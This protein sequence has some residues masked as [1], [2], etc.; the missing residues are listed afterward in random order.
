DRHGRILAC[1][2]AD[3]PGSW[4]MPQGGIDKGE[5]PRI[6]ALRE[7]REEIG[8]CAGR[9][10]GEL[11]RTIRYE[12]PREVWRKGYRGQEQRYFLFRL[13]PWAKI[14]VG[15]AHRLDPKI[16]KEFRRVEFINPE[17]FMKRVQG[18]KVDA[19]REALCEVSRLY[20]RLLCSTKKV[21]RLGEQ[22]K[23]RRAL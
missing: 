9:F 17:S 3:Y 14:D 21:K 2:R 1:E 6:A 16:R 13:S 18:F 22:R 19:Y 15:R 23:G 8:T 12:W 7:L 5:S 20:P 10:V 4:Q 11:P